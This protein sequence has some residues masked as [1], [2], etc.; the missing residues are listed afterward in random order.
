MSICLDDTGGVGDAGA[1]AAAAAVDVGDQNA[2]C[3]QP[4]FQSL[5]VCVSTNH[6]LFHFRESN[7]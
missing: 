4:S 7:H 1:A 3:V 5:H 6:H 2:G